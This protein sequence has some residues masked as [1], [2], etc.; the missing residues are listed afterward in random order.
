MQSRVETIF[1]Y[2]VRYQQARAVWALDGEV[3]LLEAL[4]WDPVL[5]VQEEE[6]DLWLAQGG[7]ERRL[8][9]LEHGWILDVG[10]YAI[11]QSSQALCAARGT[12][13]SGQA[14]KIF[15]TNPLTSCRGGHNLALL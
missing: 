14:Q 6:A 3:C 1:A 11:A 2:G 5:V 4:R 7:D 8:R 13:S 9:K 10:D 12:M 15:S